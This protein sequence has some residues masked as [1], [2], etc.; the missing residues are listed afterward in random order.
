ME[1]RGTEPALAIG[2]GVALL[3][4]GVRMIRTGTTRAYGADLRRL[5]AGRAARAPSAFLAGLLVTLVL[6]SGTAVALITA[7]FAGRNLLPLESGIALLLGAD[8]AS[9]ALPQLLA[10]DLGPLQ[11]V[12][13]IAGVSLFLLAPNARA[14]HVGRIAIGLGLVLLALRLLVESAAPLREAATLATLAQL[15]AGLPLLALLSAA[16]ATWAAHS[17]LALVIALMALAGHVPLPAELFVALVL[18]VNLGAGLPAFVATLGAPEAARRPVVGHLLMRGG[19]ALAFLPLAPGLAGLLRGLAA[20][21]GRWVV[22]AHLA[23]NLAL[24]LAGLPLVRPVGWLVRRLVPDRPSPEDERR[25]R[26]LDPGALDTPAEALACAAREALRMGDHVERMLGRVIA[27]FES[28]DARLAHDVETEDDV[29]DA[30]HEAIK[31]YLTSVTRQDLDPDEAARHYEILSF[32]TNLEHIGDIIDKNLM[33]LAA[34]KM[35]HRLR[36][37]EEGFA[38]I[39]QFH[40]MVLDNFKLAVNVFITR[41]ARLARELLERKV[42]ARDAERQATERHLARLRARLALS[43]ETSS[44]HLDVIRDLKRINSHLTA[45]AYPILERRGELARSRLS[46]PAPAARDP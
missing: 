2:G 30:L 27:V 31:I 28:D 1:G 26:H 15:L 23:F 24:A 46:P 45:V 16:L 12:L 39:R 13:L 42:A 36:F 8:V 25:P 22:D 5:V 34:K 10:R 44:L 3:L 33:E 43:I 20:D 19:L 38:E 18:G 9:A 14:R 21:P 37:S 17:S 32:T 11:P 4:W 7:S 35:R 41:D 40:A 6:Q 29:L